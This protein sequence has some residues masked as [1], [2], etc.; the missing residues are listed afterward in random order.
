MTRHPINFK[1][2]QGYLAL[3]LRDPSPPVPIAVRKP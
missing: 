1:I 3:Q 2:G